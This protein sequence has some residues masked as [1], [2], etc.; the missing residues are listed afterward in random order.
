MFVLRI[1]KRNPFMFITN[2]IGLGVALTTVIFTLTYIRYELSY[3]KHFKTK[4]RVVRLYSRVTD[5]T[6]TQVY[7][8][9]LRQAYTQLPETVPEIESAVQL[10]GGWQTSVQ[11]KENTIE[12]VRVFYSDPE[13]FNVF[14]L[15]LR[16]GNEKT[17][18][19]GMNNAVITTSVAEKLFNSANCIGKTIE[20]NGQQ[21]II[22]G[23]MDEI[24]KNSHVNFDLLISLSTA[25][26]DWFGGLEFQTYYLL[27]PN[28]DQ[29]AARTKI[30]NANNGLM[31]DWA[32]ATNSNVQ[33]GVEPLVDLYLHSAA[34]LYIPNHGSLSQILIVGLIALFVLLTALIS[35]INLFII[36]G[37]KRIA[38]ISTRT[39]FG[40]TKLSIARLF[41][42]ETSIVFLFSSVLAF[43]ITYESMPYISN[44]LLSKVDLSDLLTVYGMGSIVLVLII[45]LVITSGYPVLYLSRMRYTLGLRGKISNTGNN[46]WFS[47][48]SVFVQFTVTA[49]FIT[50]VIIIIAQLGFMHNV[51]LGFDKNNVTTITGCSSPISNKYESVKNELLK[52]P[53]VTAVC[54]G[55][56]FMGGGCSGQ[57]IRPITEGE[58]N[59]KAINEYREKPGF[60]ELMKL[61]LIDGRFFRASMADSQSVILNESA[62]KLLGLE[63]KAGQTVFYKWRR[64]DIIGVVKDFYYLSNPGEPIAPLVIANC[65]R[66]TPYL[67]IRSVNPLTGSQLMQIKSI[68]L[69]FDE[70][71]IFNYSTL[72][73]VFDRMYRKENR[74]ARMVSIG[75]AEVVIISLISLLALTILKISRRTKE[76]GIRKVNGSS[77]SQ[78]ISIL[79]KETLIIVITAILVA[80]VMS[81]L[82]MDQWLTDYVQRI[83]LHLGYFLLS[84]LFVLVIAIVAIIWQAWRAATKNPVEALRYE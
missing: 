64:V 10:Y 41:F 6:S 84:A 50:C 71:Y 18:L 28:I 51:P 53:F 1:I 56:H 65:Y 76:I 20:S 14:G 3:D 31:Q 70:D 34:L 68:F 16:F 77:I 49:F 39:I 23:V 25:N 37:E 2:V 52:L 74:L 43:L 80:S 7:G 44:L 21:M 32:K 27:K 78:V 11:N 13:I 17:A 59:N 81:Y 83:H 38:E 82:V 61:Q 45:L 60:G 75:G 57:Y 29:Q 42:L 24:P 72:A 26:P 62:I 54:G 46:N 5:N 47:T 63:P 35:Y 36:Q 4:E 40:A 30:A 55:E 58:N 12:K 69:H 66:G 73:D 33:S 8:I 9:S 67:Y 48:A 22:T 19:I 15:S 79:L